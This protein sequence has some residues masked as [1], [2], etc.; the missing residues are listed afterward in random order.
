M[1]KIK[2]W[3]VSALQFHCR[4][5]C[6]NSPIY[7]SYNVLLNI[8]ISNRFLALAPNR[9]FLTYAAPPCYKGTC[10][11]NGATIDTNSQMAAIT[12][13]IS[14]LYSVKQKKTTTIKFKGVRTLSINKETSGCFVCFLKWSDGQ[15]LRNSKD[16]RT[17]QDFLIYIRFTITVTFAALW[18]AAALSRSSQVSCSL[19][20]SSPGES[21]VGVAVRGAEP[22]P[23]E[24]VAC[25]SVQGA[26]AAELCGD[27]TRLHADSGSAWS[28][29][30]HND[31]ERS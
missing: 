12:V 5:I 8:P 11:N 22:T 1:E 4:T 30:W 26:E 17:D 15:L 9:S 7:H 24:P 2:E 27:A 13:R 18:L 3:N 6:I 21:C 31:T 19:L 20:S 23:T 25:V 10:T 14:K 28:W 29:R 16:R